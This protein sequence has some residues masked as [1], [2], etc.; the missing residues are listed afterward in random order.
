MAKQKTEKRTKK[1]QWFFLIIF[2]PVVF[3]LI[4]GAV[5]L[6]VLGV[7]V[8]DL[9]KSMLNEV[10]GISME[11]DSTETGA[12]ESA[13]QASQEELA[14]K[15]EE[16]ASLEQQLEAKNTEIQ[17][18][19]QEIETTQVE[20]QAESSGQEQE[21][22]ALQETAQVYESMGASAAA[23]I[24]SEMSN[25]EVVRHLSETGTEMRANI[26]AEMEPQRASVILNSMS[27]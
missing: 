7:N 18:L 24:L 27:E 12:E 1:G 13:P 22:S 16:I 5:L 6:S 14:A 10:P 11:A 15:E 21:N 23:S 2:V 20:Q 19:E 9:G 4:L 17:E 3:A 8:A 25:E 26:L